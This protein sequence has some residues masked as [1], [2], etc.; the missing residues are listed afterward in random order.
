MAL[1]L[2]IG[3]IAKLSALEDFVA[4]NLDIRICYYV[5]YNVHEYLMVWFPL[6]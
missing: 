1:Q 2:Y 4:R 5:I 3:V 6:N